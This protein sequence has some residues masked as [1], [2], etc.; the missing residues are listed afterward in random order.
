[1]RSKRTTNK[2]SKQKIRGPRMC[3]ELRLKL[4]DP[5]NETFSIPM[6]YADVLRQSQTI[7]NTIS[8]NLINVMWTEAKSVNLY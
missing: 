1:M 6:K 7:R 3:G 5:G 4:F 8:V 2:G